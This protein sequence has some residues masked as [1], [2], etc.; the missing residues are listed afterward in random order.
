MHVGG[1]MWGTCRYV[2][3][4]CEGGTCEGGTCEG[5]TC[6]GG[7]CEGGT[8]EGGHVRGDMCYLRQRVHPPQPHRI[9]RI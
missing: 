8:C 7:T 4:T 1:I 2:T 9:R 3:K 5:G 6:E